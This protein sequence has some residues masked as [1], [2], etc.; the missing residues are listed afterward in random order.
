M[1]S[2]IRNYEKNGIEIY[3]D[4]K[5]SALIRDTL[6]SNGWRWNGYSKCWYNYY[7]EKNWSFAE[8]I[9]DSK[10]QDKAIEKKDSSNLFDEGVTTEIKK[11]PYCKGDKVIVSIRDKKYVGT[12][13]A[14]IE[15]AEKIG[16]DYGYG[17]DKIGS[18][19]FSLEEVRKVSNILSSSLNEGRVVSFISSDAVICKGEIEN[20][21][22]NYDGTFDI[23][24]YEL[25]EQGSIT[26]RTEY[27]VPAEQIIEIEYGANIY[28]VKIGDKVE[29]TKDCGE[30][31]V[32]KISCI[33]HDG[34]IDV[35]YSYIDDWGD[36]ETNTDYYISLDEVRVML[37]GRRVLDRSEYIREESQKSIE[38]NEKIKERIKNRTDHFV[39][40]DDIVQNKS[41][42]RHQKAG[43]MLAD[44]YSKFAFFYDTGTG[45]TVMA[46]DI[47]KKKQKQNDARFLIIAPKSIIKTAWIDDATKYYPELRIMP[48]YNGFDSKKKR[49]LLNSWRTNGNAGH[50]ESDPVFYA[51]V[52]MI[53][54]VYEL[55]EIKVDDDT[56]VEEALKAEAKHYIMNSERFIR[57]P[58]KYISELD[59]TGIIMDES[60]ILKNYHGKTAKVMRAITEKLDYVYL[61]SGKPAPNNIIEYF[62]QMKIVDPETFSMSYEKF[63]N[64]FCFTLDGKYEMLPANRDLLAEMIS[65]RSLIISKQDC[66]DLPDTVDVVRQIQIPDEIMQDYNELYYECMTI[67]KGMDS[68]KHFY[69]AQSRLAILMKLRQMASGF[70]MTSDGGSKVI[71]DIHDAK[72]QELN[73]IIDQIEEEQVIIWCQFQHEI[74]MVAEELS[75]RGRTVTAYGKTKNLEDNID[76]FKTG[77]AQYIVAHPKTLKYGVTFI[78]CKYTVYYSFSYSAEDYDQSH[79]RNYRLGQTE[80]CTYIYIQ[81]VDTIDEIMHEKV[82][83]KLSNAEFFERLI[84]DAAKHGIDYDT[85][86]GQ[87]DEAIKKALSDDSSKLGSIVKDITDKKY[88]TRNKENIN[89]KRVFTTYDYL[90]KIEEPSYSELLW[91][92]E[93]FIGQDN[94]LFLKDGPLSTMLIDASRKD[95]FDFIHA[96]ETPLPFSKNMSGQDFLLFINEIPW[97]ERWVYYMYREVH[98]ELQ[99][100]DSNNAE[101]L[102]EKY[103]LDDGKRRSNKIVAD[104]LRKKYPTEKGYTWNISRV[105]AEL[106]DG[107]SSLK[108]RGELETFVSE[109]EKLFL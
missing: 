6:K 64:M 84:K 91:L 70:F 109:I 103:G 62:S 108:Y 25:D 26:V 80:K 10:F 49:A 67:I 33:N 43:T 107:L 48:I 66:L 45:K 51:H 105:A 17:N 4:K 42:Y 82:M 31:T 47:L 5:P 73:N 52:K 24:Y 13:F 27:D 99:L 78:N 32:G 39:D 74:E 20:D 46:L 95:Y 35:E 77:K 37:K 54:D 85:L 65:A 97:D 1:T 44:M 19:Y 93:N 11:D 61:L 96:D 76:A 3:F 9:C 21:N 90:D 14:Y 94:K 18:D 41:L 36:K 72:L 15:T 92:E 83:N 8:S 57:E 38:V 79:D 87:D 81:A 69:S 98:R 106:Q 7:S 53:A 100:I 29:Y 86:K 12:V 30:K 88:E 56:I 40:T 63:I 23:Y 58:E 55:G 101:V 60:A 71:V 34:T 28:P 2:Y 50:W 22:Y 102:K 75:K 59:I 89:T 68:S 16:I 104:K